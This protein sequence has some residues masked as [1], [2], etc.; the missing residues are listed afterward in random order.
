[1]SPLAKVWLRTLFVQASF[2]FDRMIGVG[3]AWA[4]QPLLKDL[5]EEHYRAAM[6][7]ATQFFNAHPYF[8]GMAIGAVARAEHQDLPPDTVDR[9]RHALISPLGSVGDKLIWAGLMPTAVGIGLTVGALASPVVGALTFLIV[10]NAGHFTLRTWAL[11]EGWRKGMEVSR[12]LTA[13]GIQRGLR[14]AGPIGGLAVGV[15]IPIVGGWLARGFLLQ[16]KLS[17]ALVALLAVAFAQW[18]LPSFRGLRFGAVA[19][20]AALIVGWLW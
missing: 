16:T 4:I 6:R 1:M 13:R 10:Y 7:R 14:L 17:V 18:I 19:A 8:A 11:R 15:A 5:P 20:I 12:A 9:L 3:S 2:S